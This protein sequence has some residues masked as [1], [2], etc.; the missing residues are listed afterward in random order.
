M[1][2][3][4]V[5]TGA[6]GSLAIPAVQHC[7]TKHPDYTLVLTVRNA[8]DTDI[9]TEKLR[10]IIARFPNVKSS[11]REL[12]LASLAAVHDFASSL[13]SEIEA[14]KLAPLASIVCNA[15][16]WN[17]VRDMELT[18]A[19]G[20]E[21]TFQVGHLAHVALVCR[22]LGSFGPS[23]GRVVLFASDAHQKGKNGLEKYPPEIPEDLEQLVHPSSSSSADAKPD[24]FG[25]GFQRYANSKLAAVMW[26]YGLN[27]ALE[28]K[29]GQALSYYS[30][31]TR[32]ARLAILGTERS[33]LI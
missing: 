18:S 31:T 23:G 28:K 24:H 9:N 33:L 10:E 27:D 5:L 26:M 14:G 19:D 21:K 3:T 16:Y 25:R 6:N 20:Y 12:D 22:L 1:V 30:T 13:T 17:M 4:I 29:V 7:L 8:S 11:I 32:L 2:G 15:Y